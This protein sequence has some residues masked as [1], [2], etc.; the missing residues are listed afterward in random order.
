MDRPVH[1]SRRDFLKLAPFAALG[2]ASLGAAPDPRA[3]LK[4]GRQRED[5][6][7]PARPAGSRP[8]WDLTTEPME[9]V[10]VGI[11]G[12]NRGR[13]HVNSCV[14]LP[15]VEV[16][17]LCDIKDDV[18]R[19]QAEVVRK[20]TG[21]TPDVHSGDENAWEKLVARDDIDVVYVATPWEWHKPM[22]VRAMEHGKHA[23]VEVN[24]GVSVRECWELVDAS[25]KY[26]RHCP[27]LENCAYGEEELFV[28]RMSAEGL[29]GDLK[30]AEGAYIHDQRGSAPDSTFFRPQRDWRRKYHTIIDGNPYPTHAIGPL[31]TYLGLGRGDI[32]TRAVS[33]S[34]PEIGLTQLREKAGA[35]KARTAS[36]RFTCG[37]MNTTLIKTARGRSIVLQ[38]DNTSPRPY[39]R[40]NALCGTEATFFGYPA[41]L[42]LDAGNRHPLLDPNEKR[43]S[44]SWTY[45]GER[46]KK[47]MQAN[48]HPLV[49]LAGEDARKVGGHGGM[50]HLM[51][52]RFL[53]CVRRGL[54]P[55]MTVYDAAAWSCL[56]EVSHLSVTSGSLP[57]E[58]P[59][60]TRGGWKTLPPLPL[61]T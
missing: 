36:E 29:F 9:K 34:S 50:D 44:H 54:T 3:L 40:I 48:P 37:D 25:E 23:F 18:A 16:R 41:R 22:A 19:A 43:N 56:L 59:D 13:A 2:T 4:D 51:N 35:D 47:F 38:H 32:M 21:K 8:V 58:I 30:H 42:A 7:F 20:K 52:F 17:A 31:A 46:L 14:A 49:K 26:R 33:V 60:F 53:D 39:S 6:S 61:I 55:D 11:I 28:R 15:W 24:C 57:V 12:L 10:R 45:E 1:A 5:S 27:I